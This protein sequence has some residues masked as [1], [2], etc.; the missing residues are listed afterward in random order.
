MEGKQPDNKPNTG[1]RKWRVA[2]GVVLLAVGLGV[3]AYAYLA[4]AGQGAPAPAGAAPGRSFLQWAEVNGVLLGLMLSALGVIISAW[5]V[6]RPAKPAQ[7]SVERLAREI[8]QTQ[9]LV[10]SHLRRLEQDGVPPEKWGEALDK[11]VEE[12][13]KFQAQAAA[14]QTED[15]QTKRLIDQGR[16]LADQAKFEEAYQKL[17]QATGRELKAATD[18]D[19]ASQNRKTNAAEVLAIK[20]HL[21]NTEREFREAAELFERAAGLVKDSEDAHWDYLEQAASAWY[22]HGEA[23]GDNQALSQAIGLRGAILDHYPRHDKPLDWARIQNNLGNALASLGEREP[24]TERLEQAVAAYEEALKEYPRKRIP[25]EWAMTQNNLGNALQRLGEREKGTER[26]DHAV[27]AFEEALKER[28]R[29]RVPLDWA[30]TQNNL[31]NALR[32]LGRRKSDVVLVRKA[33]KAQEA[34]LEVAKEAGQAHYVKI[35]S[36]NLDES[37]QA[38]AEL[39]AKAGERGE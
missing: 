2:L 18:L 12:Y 1:G 20:A 19:R 34:A 36:A 16:E 15:P 9:E 11:I 39:Q 29:E 3:L 33:V 35:I 17:D 38:L 30:M 21:K 28:T 4:P 6:F 5:G 7:T 37:R 10:K 23:K 14:F 13:R 8:G 22:D 27:W 24:G 32:E 25:L 31:G 26:L